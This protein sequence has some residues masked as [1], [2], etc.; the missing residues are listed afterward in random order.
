[1]TTVAPAASASWKLL[2][3]RADAEPRPRRRALLQTV[4][5]HL[6]SEVAGDLDTTMA[7]LTDEPDYRVWGATDHTGPHGRD[8]IR[9]MYEGQQVTGKNLL[10]WHIDRVLAD[11]DA[12]VTEGVFR[13][14]Y[15]GAQ[16]VA[17]GVADPADVAP[18]ERYLIE[19]RA[20]VVWVMSAGGLIEGE[21]T[22]KAGPARV[23]RRLEDGELPH[24]GLPARQRG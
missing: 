12:V 2:A 21:D 14:A 10:E 1:M 20:L 11:D 8:A 13:H 5:R 16:L 3:E 23:V 17:D 18:D 9:R 6:E 4:L 24:L 7:T 22:Y 15:R 19:Y